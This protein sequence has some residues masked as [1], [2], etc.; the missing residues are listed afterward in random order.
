[1]FTYSTG[2]MD[3]LSVHIYTYN[4]GESTMKSGKFETIHSRKTGIVQTTSKGWYAFLRIMRG[5]ISAD[6]FSP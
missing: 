6:V 2:D 1:M 3:I 4:H 5:Y